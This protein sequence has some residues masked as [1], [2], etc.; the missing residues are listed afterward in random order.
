MSF[1]SVLDTVGKDF[2]RGLIAVLGDASKIA[3]AEAPVLAKLNPMAGAIAGQIAALTSQALGI[4]TQTEQK[5]Q[6]L[7]HTNATTAKKVEEV[8]LILIPAVAQM[9]GLTGVEAAGVAKE[10]AGS[11]VNILSVLPSSVLGPSAATAAVA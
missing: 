9:L 8:A 2:E 4:A 5:L 10:I 6:A 7:G 1:I 3:S 11:A